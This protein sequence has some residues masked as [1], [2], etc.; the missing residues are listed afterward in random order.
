METLTDYLNCA[1]YLE[2]IKSY[3]EADNLDR[4]MLAQMI[5]I[6]NESW[7]DEN[8]T[9]S[10]A[11]IDNGVGH[12][13]LAQEK[14]LY[15][16]NFDLD[17]FGIYDTEYPITADY[18]EDIFR[19][20]CKNYKYNEYPEELI[21]QYLNSLNPNN[22]DEYF[23]YEENCELSEYLMFKTKMPRDKFLEI[24]HSLSHGAREYCLET[25]GW[26]RLENNHIE[27]QTLDKKSVNNLAHGLYE[28]YD[29]EVE[30]MKFVIEAHKPFKFFTNVSY[31][32][33]ETGAILNR[34]ARDNDNEAELAQRPYVDPYYKYVGAETIHK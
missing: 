31:N 15:D 13:M 25:H 33:I 12:E 27:L 3:Q 19:N 32:E 2:S 11:D 28:A 5:R 8:G 9:A 10:D 23:D 29:E 4:V 34:K 18:A 6:A 1:K 24:W 26:I 30:N 22:E 20:Y 16:L 17:D 14:I 7:I 21:E